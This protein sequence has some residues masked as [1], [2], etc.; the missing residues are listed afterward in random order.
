MEIVELHRN[1]IVKKKLGNKNVNLDSSLFSFYK[2]PK[3]LKDYMFY[4]KVFLNNIH[5]HLLVQLG[6]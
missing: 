5:C 1:I 4:L 3:T 6:N 2:S